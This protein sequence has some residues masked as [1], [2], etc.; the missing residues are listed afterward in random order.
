MDVVQIRDESRDVDG[1]CGADADVVS[2]IDADAHVKA[3]V[4]DHGL[5]RPSVYRCTLR[6]HLFGNIAFV[7]GRWCSYYGQLS[8]L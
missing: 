3:T 7:A 8:S 5:N 1:G 2:D 4:H 6:R